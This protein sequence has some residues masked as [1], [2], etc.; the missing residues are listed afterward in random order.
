MN[1]TSTLIANY[2]PPCPE[3]KEEPL[4]S[5]RCISGTATCIETYIDPHSTQPAILLCKV[6]FLW[7][8]CTWPHTRQTLHT[9]N[10]QQFHGRT[11]SAGPTRCVT[12]PTTETAVAPLSLTFLTN[13]SAR[14]A[15]TLMSRPPEVWAS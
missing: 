13:L 1:T 14:S 4:P 8:A 3:K 11:M 12:S 10:A 6:G 5:G 2:R 9:K 15:G 7:L